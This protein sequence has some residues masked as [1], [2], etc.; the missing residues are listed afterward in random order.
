[1]RVSLI[2]INGSDKPAQMCRLTKA[3]IAGIHKVWMQMKT[4]TKF[5][6]QLD[7]AP[8]VYVSMVIYSRHRYIIIKYRSSMIMD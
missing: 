1:M 3:F 2:S 5:N 6:Y 4:R 8:A 7:L